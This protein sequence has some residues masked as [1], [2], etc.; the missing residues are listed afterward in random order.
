M[1]SG[2]VYYQVGDF[3]TALIYKYRSEYFQPYVSNG[4]RLRFVDEVGVWEARASYK[5]N[6]NVRVKVS[7]IN[8]FSEPRKDFF[9]TQGNLGQ[10]SDYGPRVF[11]GVS[12]KY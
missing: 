8:L 4:T 9:Y 1:F 10:V 2:Q 6:K 12:V 5:V 3:D 11:A 7:A